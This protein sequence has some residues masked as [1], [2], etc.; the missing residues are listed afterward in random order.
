MQSK[1]FMALV[2]FFDK[3]KYNYQKYHT[4][5]YNDASREAARGAFGA[6]TVG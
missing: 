4:N 2:D 5:E 3:S 6:A 1:L